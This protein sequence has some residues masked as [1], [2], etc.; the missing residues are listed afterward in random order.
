MKKKSNHFGQCGVCNKITQTHGVQ[1]LEKIIALCSKCTK[2]T[3]KI[4]EDHRGY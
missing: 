2:V 4:I 3:K 1:I